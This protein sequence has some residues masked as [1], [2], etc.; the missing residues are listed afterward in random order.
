MIRLGKPKLGAIFLVVLA[1]LI[2]AFMG[3]GLLHRS[4]YAAEPGFEQD[5]ATAFTNDQPNLVAAMFYS[6]WCSSCAVLDPKLREIAPEFDGRAVQFVKFDFTMGPTDAMARK[7][8]ALG[9]GDIYE[10]NRGATG[11]M[12]LIDSRTQNVLSTI[13]MTDSE[14]DIRAKLNEAILAAAI[15]V[16]LETASRRAAAG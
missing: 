10:A 13:Y 4:G 6:A 12:A 16:E 11:F 15:P 9:V 7:A 5:P 3:R 8:E 14:N 2:A 1:L